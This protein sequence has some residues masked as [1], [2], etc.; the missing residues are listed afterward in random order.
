MRIFRMKMLLSVIF[1]FPSYKK[2][3]YSSYLGTFYLNQ[4]FLQRVSINIVHGEIAKY[5]KSR[6][7]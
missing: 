4:G 1:L 7:G 5:L 3:N 6:L 2:V